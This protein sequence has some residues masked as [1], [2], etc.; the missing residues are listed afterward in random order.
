MIPKSI[1]TSWL[2][3]DWDG[4]LKSEEAKSQLRMSLT[5]QFECSNFDKIKSQLV[6][7][8]DESKAAMN[9]KMNLIT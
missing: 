8:K 7:K 4:K 3:L 6:G 2:L 9:I 1:T 5:T